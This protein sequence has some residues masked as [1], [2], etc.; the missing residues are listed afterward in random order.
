MRYMCNVCGTDVG[1]Q[2]V[3]C[4]EHPAARVNEAPDPCGRLF[5]DRLTGLRQVCGRPA[6]HPGEHHGAGL[7]VAGPTTLRR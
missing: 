3:R 6:G 5:I 7:T 1:G 2:G 4:A